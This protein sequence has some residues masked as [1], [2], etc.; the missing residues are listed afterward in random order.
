MGAL[1]A[2]LLGLLGGA[3]L[4]LVALAT[5]PIH[6]RARLAAQPLRGR[7][8]VAPFGGLVPVTV[9]D[10]GRPRKR[11]G[12]TAKRPGHRRRRRK[13]E[14]RRRHRE[15]ADDGF[16]FDRAIAELPAFLSGLRRSVRVQRL[17][18]DAAFGLHDP[19]ETGRLF[20]YLTPALYAVPWGR[21]VRLA[22][23]PDFDGPALR[24]T[25]EAA[26][27]VTLSRI[28]APAIVFAWRVFGPGR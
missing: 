19:A 24:G 15:D 23:A 11:P 16:P 1:P 27:S 28:L 3:V 14:K 13:R 10:S 6:V 26:V 20:G 25:A 12:K 4:I 5:T 22:V 2:I 7:V 21:R 18:I 9:F 17:R 8:V